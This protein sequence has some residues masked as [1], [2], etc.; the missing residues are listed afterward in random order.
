MW[1]QPYVLLVVTIEEWKKA[2][3]DGEAHVQVVGRW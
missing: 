3:S 1:R 2:V